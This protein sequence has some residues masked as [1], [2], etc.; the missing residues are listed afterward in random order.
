MC[1]AIGMPTVNWKRV[2]RDAVLISLLT[3]VGGF[4]MSFIGKA[5]MLAV[6][7]SNI[8]LSIIGFAI[9]G[10]L[11]RT[12]RLDHLLRVSILVWVICLVNLF[13]GASL[14]Q[15][16]SSSIAILFSCAVGGGISALIFRTKKDQS[17]AVRE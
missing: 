4:L 16:L 15:W 13:F 1:L 2:I 17:V 10:S 5:S 11:T 12:N 3:F 6:G 9:S 7:A 14:T 8:G